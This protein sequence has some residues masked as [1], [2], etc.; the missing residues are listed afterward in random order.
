M[1]DY[2]K[3]K[4]ASV[5]LRHLTEDYTIVAPFEIAGKSFTIS[6]DIVAALDGD[7]DAVDIHELA[8]SPFDSIQT[9]DLN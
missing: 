3:K 4:L 9:E 6:V 1:I 2:F 7:R 8:L 5:I